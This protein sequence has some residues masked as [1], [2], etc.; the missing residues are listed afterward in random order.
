VAKRIIEKNSKR[1][2]F[3]PF[4]NKI[5]KNII[6]FVIL[7]L[8]IAGV[9]LI[10]AHQTSYPFFR[11]LIISI[12]KIIHDNLFVLL[13]YLAVLFIFREQLNFNAPT[14]LT[15][16]KVSL[17]IVSAYFS[18]R[19]F[20]DLSTP[21]FI[22]IIGGI[23]FALGVQQLTGLIFSAKTGKLVYKLDGWLI[24]VLLGCLVAAMLL[25]ISMTAVNLVIG[26]GR[27]V[28]FQESLDKRAD[29][30]KAKAI[31][32]NAKV[33]QKE[34]EN[35][36]V[37]IKDRQYGNARYHADKISTDSTKSNIQIS[38]D[39]KLFLGPIQK[40]FTNM[41]GSE[42]WG[43]FLTIFFIFSISFSLTTLIV[44][45]EIKEQYS[46]V[47]KS[48]SKGVTVTGNEDIKSVTVP[49]SGCDVT[50]GTPLIVPVTGNN[51]GNTKM[52]FQVTG[53]SIRTPTKL[54]Q[55][56]IEV[57]HEYKKRNMIDQMNVSKIARH[58]NRSRK[59]VYQT[60]YDYTDFKRR[61]G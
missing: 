22:S 41:F 4:K 8:V 61:E 54:Q 25:D 33:A 15:F 28:I 13:F 34:L 6:L 44:V 7:L 57:Y 49:S 39:Q 40:G 9:A 52:G 30:E 24:L 35:I 26:E 59:F 37:L 45:M 60:L 10:I 3:N 55:E 20:L 27:Y 29:M 42:K 53:N 38:Q 16:M 32:E 2:R 46:S 48:V 58:A 14:V 12:N 36:N 23:A 11:Q 17:I 51:Q 19:A 21:Y 56:I 5:N 18:Y 31:Q 43:K 47:P 50:P 1:F